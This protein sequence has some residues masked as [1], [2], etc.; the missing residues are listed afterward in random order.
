MNLDQ[1]IRLLIGDMAV[2]L[3]VKNAEIDALKDALAAEEAKPKA[4]AGPR[5][6]FPPNRE[7]TEG[8]QIA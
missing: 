5:P 3:A 1:H 8:A 2:N 6:V 7:V 4:E